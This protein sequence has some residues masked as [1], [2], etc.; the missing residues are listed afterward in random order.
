MKLPLFSDSVT[1]VHIQCV[2]CTVSTCLCIMK[3]SGFFI[4]GGWVESIGACRC[5]PTRVMLRYLMIPLILL[6]KRIGL[7]IT[8][9]NLREHLGVGSPEYF[10]I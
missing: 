8:K 9:N 1:Y 4:G 7:T 6:K 3:L 10:L 5:E 2:V